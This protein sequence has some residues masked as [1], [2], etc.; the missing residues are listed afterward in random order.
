MTVTI[1]LAPELEARLRDEAARQGVD[2]GTYVTH[3]TT[4]VLGDVKDC[5][6]RFGRIDRNPPALPAAEAELLQQINAGPGE[7]VWRR[8][9]DLVA[10]RRAETLSPG[11]HAELVGLSDEIEETNA[12]RL[13]QLVELAR[14]RGVGLPALMNALGITA[15]PPLDPPDRG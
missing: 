6:Q 7:G 3:V 15:P 12:R 11:E 10:K 14:L 1:D 2:V 8:Y 5:V 9:H 4:Y 13:G